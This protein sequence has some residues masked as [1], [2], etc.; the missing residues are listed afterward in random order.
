MA[1][2]SLKHY[3]S[4]NPTVNTQRTMFDMSKTDTVTINP[5]IYY[6]NYKLLVLPGDTVVLDYSNMIRMLDPL[7]VPMMD[8]LYCDTHFWFVP[9]D[10]VW[11]YTYNFFGQKKR[12]S[13]PTINSLPQIKF[14]TSDLPQVGSVYDYFGIP[15][16][17]NDYTSGGSQLPLLTGAFDVQALP[18]LS[19]YAIHDDWIMDEQRG[20]YLLDTPDFTAT[21]FSPSRF[22]LYK[23]GKR[24]D[25]FTSTILEPNMPS[26]TLPV[27]GSAP[28]YGTN[29]LQPLVIATGIGNNTNDLG[30]WAYSYRTSSPNYINNNETIASHG[31]TLPNL[32]DTATGTSNN[33]QHSGYLNVATKGQVSYLQGTIPTLTSGLV[34][35]LS[36]A[37]ATSIEALRRAFQVQAYQEILQRYGTRFPEYLYSMYGIVSDDLLNRRCEFLGSTHQRLSVSPIVQNSQSN[38]N[39][40]LGDLGAIVSGGVSE[41]VFT[42]SFTKFGYIIG[43][44]N[45]YADL[46][47]FQGL[48]RDWSLVDKMDFPVNIFANLTDQ[49]VYK[50]EIVLTGTATD[51]QVFGY[52][53]IYAWAKYAQNSLRGLVR[54]NAPSS[55]GYWSLAQKFS[56]VPVND[57]TFIESDTDIG[58][59]TSVASGSNAVHFI[60]NQK[61][62][63]KLTRELPAHSDPMKWFTRG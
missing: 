40:P 14:T 50:K 42:R 29:N 52:Q 27:A 10:N 17:G 38:A 33:T 22:D 49:P 18:L 47:Y 9:F 2:Q 1:K 63:V 56:S 59:I 44:I 13:E 6:P 11:D 23:R 26:T 46:T 12:P 53:E 19:Y 54:P 16:V 45:I 60:C 34:A 28:V 8:N 7:Q 57:N 31:N 20:S 41:P 55:V 30:Y 37:S 5:D 36:G 39:A 48:E 32:N 58:R 15:I 25:Y 21:S 43:C 61:F 3:F 51:D 4:H 35:D 62:D 24:F